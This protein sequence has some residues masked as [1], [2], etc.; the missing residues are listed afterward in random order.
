MS[1]TSDEPKVNSSELDLH[2]PLKFAFALQI[3]QRLPI[4]FVI[5]Q[6]LEL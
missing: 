1:D 5:L 6:K 4:M 3:A 2:E